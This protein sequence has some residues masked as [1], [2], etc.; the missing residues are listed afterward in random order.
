M[1]T[2]RETAQ[3][4]VGGGRGILAA[5]ESIRTMS[6]RLEAA[7]VAASEESRRRYRELLVTTPGLSRAVSGVILCDETLRQEFTL[8][9][10]PVPV[11]VACRDLGLLPG[12]KV[13]TGVTPLALGDGALITEGLD[14]LRD[15]LVE[16]V[17]LGAAFAK[18]RAVIDVTTVTEMSAAANAHALAR[19]AA[20]CQEQGL[21]PIVEPEV[22]YDGAH[23]LDAC[24][25]ATDLILGH[26]FAQLEQQRVDLGAIVLKPNFVTPGLESGSIPALEVAEATRTVLLRRVPSSVPG[27]AFLS[28]G[29]DTATACG[30]LAALNS[31]TRPVP[32][33]L[34]FSFGRA[35]V[36]D[37]LHGW[38]GVE[39]NA[40]AAQDIL[41]SN[42]TRAAA[43]TGGRLEPAA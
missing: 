27:I 13:D 9:E 6:Q 20:L 25:S 10:E 17:A 8:D 14:G 15:R 34:T 43:A 33:Q 42:C 36:S 23:D 3:A 12:I 21:V 31:E 39:A 4:L 16:Y 5:D 22:L 18:W 38:A 24:R 41:L 30:F 32:W 2:L 1:T 19:Y 26:V 29:H 7:G 37:A 35:L 28:G 11:G 40:A